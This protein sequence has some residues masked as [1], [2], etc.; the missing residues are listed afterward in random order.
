MKTKKNHGNYSL[1]DHSSKR[2]KMK[3][4]KSSPGPN[5]ISLL[6]KSIRVKMFNDGKEK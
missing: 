1:N 6:D 3:S 4:V 2:I 5:Q